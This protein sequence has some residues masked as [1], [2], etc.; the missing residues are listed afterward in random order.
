MHALEHDRKRRS[1]RTVYNTMSPRTEGT[2]NMS[3]LTCEAQKRGRELA[4][5]D[6]VSF[7]VTSFSV[8]DIIMTISNVIEKMQTFR[9]GHRSFA[10]YIDQMVVCLRPHDSLVC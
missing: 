2:P 4:V 8:R 9:A 1:G 6:L 5:I 10:R 7:W 3:N